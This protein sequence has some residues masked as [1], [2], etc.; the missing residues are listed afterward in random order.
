[1]NREIK[2]RAWDKRI[3]LFHYWDFSIQMFDNTFW[4]IVKQEKCPTMQFTGLKD[5]NNKDIYEGDKTVDGFIEFNV[6]TCCYIIR[7][8]NRTFIRLDIKKDNIEIIGNI[9]ETIK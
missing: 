5:K 6:D 7:R 4:N 3:N 1:M 9:Y 8:V 2:F